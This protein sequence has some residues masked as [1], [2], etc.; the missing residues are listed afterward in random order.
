MTSGANSAMAQLVALGV[1][2]GQPWHQELREYPQLRT[3]CQSLWTVHCGRSVHE[4]VHE[5]PSADATDA[6]DAKP[7]ASASGPKHASPAGY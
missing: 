2:L 4:S 5:R 6:T 7:E 3:G 1:E